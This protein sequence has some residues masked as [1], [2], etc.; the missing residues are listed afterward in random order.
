MNSAY[1][2]WNLHFCLSSSS[3]LGHKSYQSSLLSWISSQSDV[4]LSF[5]INTV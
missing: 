1:T 5:G 4:D 2:A 3:P